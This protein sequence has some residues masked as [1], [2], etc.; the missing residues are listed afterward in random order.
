DLSGRFSQ[1]FPTRLARRVKD[2][3]TIFLVQE[4]IPYSGGDYYHP[5]PYEAAQ[6]EELLNM[7]RSFKDQR[8]LL[9]LPASAQPARRFLRTLV[10]QAP[11]ESRRLVVITGDSISFNTIYRDRD[12]AWNIQDMPVPLLFFSHRNPVDRAAGFRDDVTGNDL[13]SSTGTQDLL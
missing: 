1:L 5:N 6:V 2:Q 10:R 12:I 3:L 4:K 13:A 8:F 7:N 9:V 11:L